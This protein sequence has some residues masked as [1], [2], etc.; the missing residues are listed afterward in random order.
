MSSISPIGGPTQPLFGVEQS[1]SS[2]PPTYLMGALNGVAQM[3]SMSPADLQKALQSGQSVAD[4]AQSK[5]VSTSA[6]TQYIEQQVQQQRASQGQPPLDSQSLDQAVNR[7]VTRHHGHHHHGGGGGSSVSQT[8]SN[9]DQ[10]L[11]SLL[12]NDSSSSSGST[13]DGN[14]QSTLD[15]FA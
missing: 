4:I 5:G 13:D 12:T 15:L 6:I 9:P 11:L 1:S 3:L 14:T 2:T 7:A 8:S 10:D